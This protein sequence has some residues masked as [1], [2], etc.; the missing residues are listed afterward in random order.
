[1]ESLATGFF[2]MRIFR[3]SK[4]SIFKTIVRTLADVFFPHFYLIARDF[5]ETNE[6]PSDEDDLHT[7]MLNALKNRDAKTCV[8][9]YTQLNED[10]ISMYRQIQTKQTIKDKTATR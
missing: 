10:L 7:V 9:A 3:V 5:F 1:M 4:K 6:V 8:E 2:H